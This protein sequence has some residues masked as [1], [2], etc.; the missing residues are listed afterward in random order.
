MLSALALVAGGSEPA[1]PPGERMGMDGWY[2][3][4]LGW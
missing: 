2:A 3:D 1:S 4:R